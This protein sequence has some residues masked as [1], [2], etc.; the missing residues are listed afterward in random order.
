[1]RCA[2]SRPRPLGVGHRPRAP[3]P[4]TGG[5]GMLA[6][7]GAAS[8][9]AGPR[10]P[11]GPRRRTRRSCLVCPRGS[12]F[13][14][15][16]RWVPTRCPRLRCRAPQRTGPRDA[17]ASYR[18]GRGGSG[19]TGGDPGRC[20]PTVGR[21]CGATGGPPCH[22]REGELDS[23][24]RVAVTRTASVLWRCGHADV[25]HFA[26]VGLPDGAR[27]RRACTWRGASAWGRPGQRRKRAATGTRKRDK[28]FP[29]SRSGSEH[30]RCRTP[31]PAPN[32]RS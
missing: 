28:G 15:H 2:G 31:Y 20:L 21:R 8:R 25:L 29:A 18:S 17:P 5:A 12:C 19:R 3:A 4:F 27:R 1:M 23:P 14:L 11:Q 7:G 10:A 16:P 30:C 24:A 6:V 32:V 22:A 26:E 13:P 9:G